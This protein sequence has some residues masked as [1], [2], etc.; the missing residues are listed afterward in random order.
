MACQS[1]YGCRGY[2]T[3]TPGLQRRQLSDALA[4]RVRLKAGVCR[5]AQRA[6]NAALVGAACRSSRAG[7][8]AASSAMRWCTLS[9]RASTSRSLSSHATSGR[10]ATPAVARCRGYGNASRRPAAAGVPARS[11]AGR[12][13]CGLGGGDAA[14]FVARLRARVTAQ[15]LLLATLDRQLATALERGAPRFHFS[16]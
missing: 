2:S 1:R 10:S 14:E 3:L 15:R 11:C 16:R 6:Q 9:I 4:P 5:V 12:L 7:F 13:S 8:G